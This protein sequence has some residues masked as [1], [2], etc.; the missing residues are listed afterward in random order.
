MKKMYHSDFIFKLNIFQI[1]QIVEETIIIF[2]N[3]LEDKKAEVDMIHNDCYFI[4]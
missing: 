1:N 2:L 4:F 3:I